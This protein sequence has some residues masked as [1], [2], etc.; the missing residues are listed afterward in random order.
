LESEITSQPISGYHQLIQKIPLTAMDL[1]L[2]ILEKWDSSFDVFAVLFSYKFEFPIKIFL[3]QSSNDLLISCWYQFNEGIPP[4]P[5][6]TLV[7]LLILIS[8]I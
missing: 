3:M 2:K 6:L 8:Y 7:F 4:Y 5:M 1:F